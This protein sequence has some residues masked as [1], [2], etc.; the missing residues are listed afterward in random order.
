MEIKQSQGTGS[1]LTPNLLC[2]LCTNRRVALR[3][4]KLLRAAGFHRNSISM[5]QSSTHGGKN[6]VYEMK[7]SIKSGALIGAVLGLL[8][9]GLYL[10]LFQVRAQMLESVVLEHSASRISGFWFTFFIL[11][12]GAGLGAACGTLVG[13]GT[14]VD[15]AKRFG[16]Y[17][18]EGGILVAVDVSGLSDESL[19][20][21]RQI[22]EQT[23]VQDISLLNKEEIMS[24]TIHHATTS[25][26]EPERLKMLLKSKKL[27]S[28]S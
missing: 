28:I 12:V 8:I 15:A 25:S 9:F 21:A 13:I 24:K 10:L 17:L 18:D 23:N 11:I 20:Q 5:F 7:T 14:P 3:V 19:N 27:P 22:L 1:A 26:I 2:G 16:F 6:F 4:K